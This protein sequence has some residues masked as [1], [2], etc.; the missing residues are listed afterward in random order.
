VSIP[1]VL[2]RRSLPGRRPPELGVLTWVTLGILVVL[3]LVAV[4]APVLAPHDPLLVDPLLANEG[5]SASH[6]LGTD[7]TGRDIF[8]RMIVGSRSS[9]LGPLLVVLIA[10][11]LG[12]ALAITAAWRGGWFDQT[13]SRFVDAMFAFPGIL[14]AI[15]AVAV[16]GRGMTAPVIALG[17]AYIPYLARVTRA[18]AVRERE[19]P[20]VEALQA[21]GL[22]AFRICFRHLLPNLLPFIVAQMST[23]FGYAMV[24]LATI[25][26]LGLG[27][28]PPTPDWGLMVSSGRTGLLEGN[29]Q[30][31][32]FPGLMIILAVMSFNLLGAQLSARARAGGR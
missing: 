3:T 7:G 11:V 16:F 18:A 5:A 14:I 29:P 27:I 30:E 13:V 20:Y 28:Q 23:A 24:D 32:L 21:Q 10:T 4:F 25:S 19:L 26:F 2:S 17:I 6:L 9:L 31:S 15:L 1:A 8:S 12:S 22:S